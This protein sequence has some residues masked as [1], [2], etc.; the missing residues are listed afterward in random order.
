MKPPAI[1]KMRLNRPFSKETPSSKLTQVKIGNLTGAMAGVPTDSGL[2][3]SSKKAPAQGALLEAQRH[4]G[5]TAT[6]R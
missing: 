3:S 4:L 2:G 1:L 6:G 5:I